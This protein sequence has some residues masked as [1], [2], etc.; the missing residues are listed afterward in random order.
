MG[1]SI[2]VIEADY[3]NLCYKV[4]I[5]AIDDGREVTRVVRYEIKM[6]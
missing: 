2:F 3:T 1:C 5:V 6:V 4:G